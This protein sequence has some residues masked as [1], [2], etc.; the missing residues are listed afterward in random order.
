MKRQWENEELIKNW[1][2]SA[3]DLA[4]L[5]NKIGATRLGFVVLLKFFKHQG[6]SPSFKNELAD[7]VISFV[8]AQVGVVP[9][10]SQ[11]ALEA[12]LSAEEQNGWQER[13]A[14]QQPQDL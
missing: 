10:A 6:R 8:A 9:E 2:F 4:Q 12:L 7:Q 3:W 13:Q 14:G 5:G 11:T 1:M